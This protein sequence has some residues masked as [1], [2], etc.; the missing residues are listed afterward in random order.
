MSEGE[1]EG[2]GMAPPRP[3][4]TWAGLVGRG[5]PGLVWTHKTVLNL[6]SG[7]VLVGPGVPGPLWTAPGGPLGAVG[8]GRASQYVVL[9]KIEG[10]GFRV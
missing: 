6:C 8:V 3:G 10:L 9:Y 7:R 1:R 4:P 2:V 5:A